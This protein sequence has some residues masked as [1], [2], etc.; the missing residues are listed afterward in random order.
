V[1]HA[2]GWTDFVAARQLARRQQQEGYEK[3]TAERDRLRD[4]QQTQREWAV[5]G[6]KNAK[7]KKTD[8][9]KFIPHL[10]SQRS[11][12]MAAKVKATEKAIERLEV[13]EK[14]WEPWQLQLSFA[15]G[16]RAGDVVAR[17]DRAE[18]QLGSFHLGPVD[19]EVA[20]QER[21]AI[22]GPNGTGKT[23]LLRAIL[24]EVPL[25]AGQRWVGP[26][27]KIGLLDQ[28]RLRYGD[29]R[30]LLASFMGATGLD[31]SEARTLL[32]KFG[33][34]ADHVDRAGA[35]LSPG[36]RTRTLLAELM[37]AGVNCLVLDEPTN[38]LDLEAIEQLE[39]ALGAFD[40]TLLLVTHDRAFLEAVH[41]N[42]TID[43]T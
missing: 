16:T 35:D 34:G 31:R 10:K 43:L 11:E 32:A 4:R 26:G 28:R 41:T 37:A 3:Y 5:V 29:D 22:L 6:V 42:R 13:V 21:V 20:W 24:G 2:G 27:V 8:N 36:E 1:E 25:S 30:P 9:D 15:G 18:V 33:L 38:H 19:L 14:P 12:K 40:G 17:L 39:S 7:K 23:T